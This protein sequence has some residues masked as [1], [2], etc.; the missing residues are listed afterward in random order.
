MQN[1]SSFTLVELLLVFCIVLVL[2]GTFFTYSRVTL[3]AAHETALV[4]EL[5][6]IRMAIE[7][8]RIT[9]GRLPDNL[10]QLTTKSLTENRLSGIRSVNAYLKDLKVDSERYP[11]DPFLKRYRYNPDDGRVSCTTY[12][13][14]NW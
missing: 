1:K 9:T 3:R 2:A 5:Q 11:L 14:E 4:N 12:G 7:F 10:A 8:Y 6:N 13:Y